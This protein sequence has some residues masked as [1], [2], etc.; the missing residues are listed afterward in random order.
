MEKPSKKENS[1]ATTK[2][3]RQNLVTVNRNE[4]T[5]ERDTKANKRQGELQKMLSEGK[6]SKMKKTVK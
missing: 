1:Q 2:V 3:E 6:M 5:L 4:N